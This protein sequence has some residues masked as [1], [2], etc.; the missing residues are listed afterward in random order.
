MCGKRLASP[1]GADARELLETLQ[2]ADATPLVHSPQGFRS[3]FTAAFQQCGPRGR[4]LLRRMAVT[5]MDRI[6]DFSAAALLDLPCREALETIRDLRARLL[7]EPLGLG[8]DGRYRYQLHQLA[9]DTLRARQPADFDLSEAEADAWGPEPTRAARERLIGAYTWLAEQ[10]AKALSHTGDGFDR[11]SAVPSELVAKLRLTEPDMPQAWLEREREFLLGCVWLAG[12]GGHLELGRRLARAFAAVCL[13]VRT[14]WEEWGEAVRAQ[15]EL[16]EAQGDRHAVAMALLDESEYA[17]SCGDYDRGVGLAEAAQAE[18]DQ[19]GAHPRWLA[20]ARRALGVN[21]QRKG[22]L[23][24]ARRE[25]AAAEG[26]FA[27][28]GQDWWRARTRCNLAEV[29]THVGDYAEAQRLLEQARDAFGDEGDTDQREYS[30]VLLAEVLAR[31]GRDLDAWILLREVRER[32]EQ[33]DRQWY[34][35]RCLRA[36]GA[37]HSGSLE[38]QYRALAAARAQS[39]DSQASGVAAWRRVRALRRSWSYRSRAAMLEEAIGLLERMG[40]MWGVHWTRLTLGRIQ[41]RDGHY[42]AGARTLDRATEGFAQLPDKLWRARAHRIIAE[43]LLAATTRS[44][45]GRQSLVAGLPVRLGLGVSTPKVRRPIE[46][47]RE[48]ATKAFTAYAQTPDHAGQVHT[49]LLLARIAR[50]A[51]AARDEIYAP[52]NHAESLAQRHGEDRLAR[53]AAALRRAFT[54]G[55]KQ[56]HAEV[57]EFWPIS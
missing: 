49:Q 52:L 16:A 8:D 12:M 15:R 37:L 24:D 50:A 25:L 22:D 33:G 2:R 3:S 1:S 14:H 41:I 46:A 53:E 47:A 4:L 55:E 57:Q 11:T 42:S 17:G 30:R 28:H 20:R 31:R 39:D 13:V 44:E 38:E 9:A 51:S 36:M 43:E 21:L 56:E 45:A 27:E 26:V 34:V 7:L 10:V 29:D 23:D 40:D 48:H 54:E 5:G 32:A 6:A 35:A 18:F 19:Q